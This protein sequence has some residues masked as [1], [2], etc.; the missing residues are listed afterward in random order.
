[1][2]PSLYPILDP[3]ILPTTLLKFATTLADAGA[4]LIQLRDKRA[5]A[6]KVYF[7]AQE[8]IAHLA[9]RGVRVIVNDRPDIAALAGA[10]G[11]HVGQGDLPVEEARRICGATRWVG[12]STHNLEQLR[13]AVTTSADYIAVGPIFPTATKE[14]PDPIVGIEFVR[15][16]RKLTRKPIVAIGGITLD[17]AASVFAAGADSIAVIRDLLSAGDPAARVRE[18][19]AVAE[20][21]RAARP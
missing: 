18:Y 13:E 9:T 19:L 17:T 21:V 8:L 15:E 14:N 3:S 1:M 16:A 20:R 5:P 2:F 6:R 12:V 11:V 10:G 7:E 4:S